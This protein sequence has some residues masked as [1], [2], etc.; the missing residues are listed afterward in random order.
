LHDEAQQE[1]AGVWPAWL[2]VP[3]AIEESEVRATQQEAR[4]E[5]NIKAT[6]HKAPEEPNV[7][8]EA[9]D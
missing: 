9:G 6:H 5:P 3:K 7:R 1:M 4:E 2:E 8:D